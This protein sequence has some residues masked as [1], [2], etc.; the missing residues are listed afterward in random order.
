MA[1]PRIV[2]ADALGHNFIP[3]QFLPEGKDE[4]YLR[5]A[6]SPKAA[7]Y[8]RQLRPGEIE[9]LIANGNTA[10]DWDNVR[11]AEKF[12]P[13]LVR[14]CQF[15]GLVRIGALQ[16]LALEYHELVTPVGLTNSRIIACDFGDNVAIHHVRHLAHYIIGDGCILLD[17]D[18]M[19]VSSHAKFGNGI[20]KDGEDES[21]AIT[22]DVMNEAGGRSILPFDGMTAGDA[23]L[24]ARY[25]E[26]GELMARLAEITRKQFDSRR[27]YY[28]TVGDGCVVKNCRI[29]KDVKVGPYAYIKGAN[30]LKN[31]TIN[32]S[33]DAPT[34]IGEGVELVNGILGCGSRAFYGCKAVRFVMG[35][36]T[37][38]KYGA[39]LIH[40]VLGDNST[41][42][43]CEVLNNLVFGAHEQHH[44]N[45]FLIASLVM[46]QSNI[47][48]G[49]TI[50][51]NH[52]SR[53]PDGELHAGRGFWPGLCVSV[54]HDST[55]ASFTL[56]A[57]GSYR[58]ELNVPLPFCLVSND[59]SA[60]RLSLMPAYWWMYN[61]YALAR[62]TWK[63]AARDNRKVKR[64][65]IEFDSL[66]PDTVEE[67]FT[68]LD[69]LE[70]W[71]GATELRRRRRAPGQ[72]SPK[73]LGEVGRGLL[74]GPA[75]GMDGLEI[76]ADHV[77]RSGRDVVVL[78][79]HAAYRAYRQM[80]HYYAVKNVLAYLGEHPEITFSDAADAL[81]GP[82]VT[83]WVNMGGQLIPAEDVRWLM[84]DI[85]SGKLDHWQ[86]IHE[87]YQ[88]LW[89]QYPLA[90]QR[91]AFATFM[92]LADTETPAADLWSDAFDQAVEIQ[93]YIA[94]QT[95]LTRNKDYENPFRRA[96]YD[97]DEQLAAVLGTVQD[98]SFVQQVG[99]ETD[100]FADLVAELK[101]R[102]FQDVPAGGR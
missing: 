29:I 67:M 30:K 101:K 35:D 56:L 17:V 54:K 43:C 8:W 65:N 48:A 12:D 7:D 90:K 99:R 27:G 79:A 38:L 20:V 97:N 26:D 60:D 31:L 40:S 59:E 10:D 25:R 45:S 49:A 84:A 74:T 77:E 46:G 95:C 88:A 3:K 44:N 33:A 91:H 94:R 6:Q 73:A 89:R 55:F 68:A 36:N 69:L 22:L 34:Q 16:G 98:N 96:L 11:V 80:L 71:V 1:G 28:G 63:F 86:D 102:L 4:Y 42:S 47:G 83:E 58:Y 72:M 93:R 9:A 66:A 2:A 15:F 57:K 24:W 14:D 85:K 37:S 19:H 78:K 100:Q 92:T 21:V 87:A 51:S 39:R 70:R 32:S 53:S 5:N 76:L 41:I 52:N 64:Q 61:M 18:E 23:Y 82:R 81:S 13:G 50:G 75:E 62:N